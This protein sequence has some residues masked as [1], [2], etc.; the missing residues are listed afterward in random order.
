MKKTSSLIALAGALA[1]LG[2]QAAVAHGKTAVKP[3]VS[4]EKK[5]NEGACGEGKCGAHGK[6]SAKAGEGKCGEGK[7]GAHG[8]K[9]A[10]AGEGKCGEGKCGAHGKKKPVKAGEGKCGEGKCGG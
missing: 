1:L 10:K 6:K 2:S 5:A 7:C 9:S 4:A 8:K 3:P